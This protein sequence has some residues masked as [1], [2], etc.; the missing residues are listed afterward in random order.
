ME[1][2]D[3]DTWEMTFGDFVMGVLDGNPGNQIHNIQVEN[4]ILVRT[5][6]LRHDSFLLQETIKNVLLYRLTHTILL[7][8]LYVH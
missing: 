5:F 1:S 7:Y 4:S 3:I 2:L 6:V 8:F